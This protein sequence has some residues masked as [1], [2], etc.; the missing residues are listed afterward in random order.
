MPI[1]ASRPRSTRPLSTFTALLLL[2]L[3][4]CGGGGGS[5]GGVGSDPESGMGPE[6]ASRLL[7]KATFGGNYEAI[8]QAALMSREAWLEAQF[9]QPVGHHLPIVE[10]LEMRREELFAGTEEEALEE[11]E[12]L[13]PFLFRRYAWWDR[14]VRAPD[15]LRQRVAFALSEI[16]V[17]SDRVEELADDPRALTG[18]ADMLLSNAFGNYRDLLRDV[19]F[20]PAMGIYLSHVNNRKA[21][22][23]NNIFPDENYAR[24][25][26]QLFSIGLFE[27]NPDGT[28]KLDDDGQPIPT[29]SNREIRGFARV[30]TGL[31][32]DCEEET[33]FGEFEPCFERPMRMVEAFHEPGEKELISGV[34]I[35]AGQPPLADIE[36]ALDT[37]FHHPNVG[38]FISRLLI[39]RLVTSNPSADYIARVTAAFEGDGSTPRGDMK[40]V[41]RAIF[42]DPEAQAA[43]SERA[44]FGKL[45]EPVLR[46]LAVAR[47]L[48]ASTSE[49]DGLIANSGFFADELLRQ[50]PFSS[51]SVFNFFL[52]DHSPIGE[53]SNAA[54]VAPEFQ[55]TT[56]STVINVTNLMAYS[57]FENQIFVTLP[58]FAEIELDIGEYV[59]IADDVEALLDRLDL[60]FTYGT[61]S[62]GTRQAI[63]TAI[64]PIED[65]LESRVRFALYLLLI[66]PDYAVQ[67]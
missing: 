28:R 13:E 24:E 21:D 37:L 29:Y 47:A 56:S 7:S 20:H 16:F 10:S 40:R 15:E 3:T 1:F 22:P 35:A 11:F 8:Q 34:V 23:V 14:A 32:F 50:H 9:E 42:L 52:P 41:L 63:R 46:Y 12:G 62:E 33:E 45:R 38:P 2:M 59:E 36:Q 67:L 65:E 57:I 19:T 25:V 26:M 58:P 4:A 5:G 17:V 60:V 48:N 44:D 53:I 64:L 43:P 31:T 30:F 39:Q 51:P 18:Y 27:L 54:L 49:A 6:A 61:L 55:I 66:S